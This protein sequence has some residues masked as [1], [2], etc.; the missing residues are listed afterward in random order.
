MEL[1]VLLGLSSLPR[2][3]TELLLAFLLNKSREFLLT[4]PE[5]AISDAAAKK[6]RALEKP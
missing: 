4:H 1:R 5:F 2:L 6:Y 3:E